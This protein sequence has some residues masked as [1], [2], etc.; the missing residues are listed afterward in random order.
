MSARSRAYLDRADPLPTLHRIEEDFVYEPDALRAFFEE[1]VQHLP[2]GRYGKGEKAG[3]WAVLS[4][5]ER[6][7]GGT[8]MRQLAIQVGEGGELQLEPGYVPGDYRTPTT[9]CFGYLRELVTRIQREL[10]P[11]RRVRFMQMDP[12]FHYM[13]HRDSVEEMWRLHF[14]VITNPKAKFQ[15]RPWGKGEEVVS[16]H[17]PVSPHPYWV[18]TDIEH[19]FNNAGPTPRVHLIM[20][21]VPRRAKAEDHPAPAA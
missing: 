20:N 2:L 21:M 19:R 5:D 14:P 13:W 16:Y 7:E 1:H 11:P 9:I 8:E 3:S 17:M 15:W 6:P 12:D 10:L 4:S 18:R